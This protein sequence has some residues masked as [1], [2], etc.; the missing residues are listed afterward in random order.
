MTTSEISA[1]PEKDKGGGAWALVREIAIVLVCAL[2]LSVLVRTFLVQAFYVPSQ[3]MENTLM[4]NDRI[5]ASKITTAISGV[6][7]GEVVVF[8]DPGGW[9][10][11]SKASVGPVSKG[12]EFIGLVPSTSGND[13]VKRVIGIAGDHVK[14]CNQQ[15]QIVLNGVG[16]DEPFIKPGGGTDQVPFDIVVPADSM[17]VMGDNRGASADSRFHLSVN[18]G[19]V[20]LDD[21]VGRVVLKVWPLDQF[22]TVGIPETFKNPALNNQSK[23]GA[24]A[25]SGAT[26]NSG[27]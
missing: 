20:P 23:S 16:L 3:S 4:P 17:F 11:D 5:L 8:R 24:T 19:A 21:V 2:V 6:T 1:P 27:S 26:P 13:L 14:C 9:L 7:R 25:G 12:L 10:P 18:D 22:G 15:G